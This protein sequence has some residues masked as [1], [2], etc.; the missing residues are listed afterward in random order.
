MGQGEAPNH[1]AFG[2][3]PERLFRPPAGRR[4]VLQER[5]PRH[6]FLAVQSDGQL[7]GITVKEPVKHKCKVFFKG[8]DTLKKTRVANDVVSAAEID[9]LPD[10]KGPGRP[11]GKSLEAGLGSRSSPFK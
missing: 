7:A 3:A 5:I 11:A 8:S 1:N 2:A 4:V 10:Y 6:N 9:Q